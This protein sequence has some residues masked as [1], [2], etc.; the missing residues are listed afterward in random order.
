MFTQR[1]GGE[2]GGGCCRG[3]EGMFTEGWGWEGRCRVEEGCLQ[4]GEGGRGVVERRDVYRG[5]GVGGALLG[6]VKSNV[7]K[8]AY[9]LKKKKTRGRKGKG[10]RQG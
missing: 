8:S 1:G 3:E 2:G 10:A 4:R 5:V 7:L 9:L 6:N